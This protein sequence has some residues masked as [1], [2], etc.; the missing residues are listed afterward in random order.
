MFAPLLPRIP[1]PPLLSS[2]LKSRFHPGCS[3]RSRCKA[4]HVRP[5]EAY[6]RYAAMSA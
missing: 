1:A 4:A 2:L 6:S 5:N 3:K